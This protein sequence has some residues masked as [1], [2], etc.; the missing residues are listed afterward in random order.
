MSHGWKE[1]SMLVKRLAAYTHLSSTISE[2]IIAI[3]WSKIATFHTPPLF[4]APAG[5]DPVGIS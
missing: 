4:S 5:D 2:L 1:D 3:Y